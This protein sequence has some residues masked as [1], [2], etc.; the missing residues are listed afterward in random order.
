MLLL[1]CKATRSNVGGSSGGGGDGGGGWARDCAEEVRGRRRVGVDSAETAR[2]CG[3]GLAS[4]GIAVSGE[5]C[6]SGDESGRARHRREEE[7]ERRSGGDGLR[8]RGGLRASR[9]LSPPT[10]YT[11]R[12][13]ACIPR[14]DGLAGPRA[15]PPPPAPPPHAAGLAAV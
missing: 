11:P 1:T 5:T 4:S 3:L 2:G 12:G 8:V 9:A 7:E 14:G 15:A 6:T 13:A 10:P